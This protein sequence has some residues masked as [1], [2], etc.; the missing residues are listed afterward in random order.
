[1]RFLS[2]SILLICFAAFTTRAQG[3]PSQKTEITE[4][5]RTDLQALARRFV[6]DLQRT[7]DVEP[8]IPRYFVNGFY[9]YDPGPGDR[10]I[11]WKSPKIP[12]KQEIR[13]AS[14][15]GMNSY[16]IFH[17]LVSLTDMTTVED[18]PMMRICE[19]ILP[20]HIAHDLSMCRD[21]HVGESDKELT[22]SQILKEIASDERGLARAR[23]FL[24]TIDLEHTP[25][26]LKEISRLEADPKM[27]YPIEVR[28]YPAGILF[29]S[30][31]RLVRLPPGT[32]TYHVRTPISFV[33][34]FVKMS[35]KYKIMEVRLDID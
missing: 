20:K 31:E 4:K 24:K 26:Y 30:G 13:R 28:D 21:E 34:I 7:R 10:D 5:Q 27:N 16:Y 8:L 14:V 11:F 25:K 33:P 32:K 23:Q 29:W 18:G 1:M 15:V 22:R 3:I 12:T 19:Q 6:A 2:F 35:G 17:L 9:T